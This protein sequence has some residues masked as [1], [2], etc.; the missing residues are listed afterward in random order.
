MFGFEF[1]FLRAY[2]KFVSLAILCALIFLISNACNS[3]KSNSFIPN[4]KLNVFP[5]IIL[6]AWE[7]PENLK[8]I[9][10]KKFGVAFLAQTLMLRNDEVIF[11]PRRQPLEISPETFLIAVTRIETE[12]LNQNQK[13]ALSDSQKKEITDAVNRTLK[14]PNVKAVQIDFDALVSERSFYQSLLKELRAELPENVSLTMTALASWCVSD[15]W[16]SDLPVD[17]A[18]PMAF[19]MGA[20]DSQIRKF[21]AK[22]EDWQEKLCRSSYGIA[23]DE[24]LQTEFQPNRRIYV[25]NNRSWRPEDLKR[26]PRGVL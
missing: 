24:P 10:T 23:L 5:P 2:F 16:F 25:F 15:S 3:V 21:L 9:D 6:W 12:K 8:F 13:P 17:E 1:S 20:D 7:R 18:V 22:G 11:R 26:L 19:R 14:L 4:E